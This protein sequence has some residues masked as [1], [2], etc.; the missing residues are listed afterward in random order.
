[1]APLSAPRL[2][3]E[4]GGWWHAYVCGAHGV[5][6]AHDGLLSGAFP[7]EGAR[8]PYG[9]RLD[10]PAVHG[11]WA[12]LAH[13]A[14]ARRIRLLAAVSPAQAL[15][16]LIEYGERYAELT[17]GGRHEQAQP[18]ML[19]GR[20]FH[21]ALS[22]AIWAV[23]LGHAAWTLAEHEIHGLD[24]LLP[25]LDSLERAAREARATLVAQD[26]FTSNYTAWLNAAGAVTARAAALI[27]GGTTDAQ[28]ARDSTAEADWLEGS[29]GLHAHILAA[30]APDGWEWEAS[31]YYHGFVLRAYL[32]QLRGTRPGDLP[33][34]VAARLLGMIAALAGTASPGGVL[35][36]LHDGPYDRP[37]TAA[38]HAELG[39]LAAGFAAPD[40]LA[41]VTARAVADA[42][43][44]HDRL[45]SFLSGWFAGPPRA[46]VPPGT[47]FPD[48]GLAVLR[49]GGVHAVLDYGPHGGSHGHHDKLALYLYG[50]HTPWQ[51]D[52]G[53]VPYAEDRWRAY[54][55]GP[56]AHP[57]PGLPGLE[58]AETTGTLDADDPGRVTASC[59][60]AY[61]GVRLTRTVLT[62]SGYLADLCALAPKADEPVVLRLRPGVP[63]EAAEGDGVV[64][65]VWRGEE[66]LRGLHVADAPAV[67]SAFPAP[68]LADDPQR[69]RTCLDWAA[70]GPVTF[71]SV[72]QA[73]GAEP[74]VLGVAVADGALRVT[75]A[76][77]AVEEHRL[78]R[79]GG[80]AEE[81][82]LVSA[83]GDA[84]ERRLP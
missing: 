37:A 5:E 76:G 61:P 69:A 39:V 45:E 59:D 7:P 63:V 46:A 78:P 29:H 26:R 58:P 43:T 31:T 16:P 11:A 66:E 54:F 41:A 80:A 70:R 23:S 40:H 1:M 19:R 44:G 57:A 74:G 12:A 64:T 18:W 55:A 22:E 79:A 33:D 77:G 27:R 38:E 83:G 81:H 53:Q 72:Y 84:E 67:L 48:A 42:G 82:L 50:E 49:A 28:E 21:Q 25:L 62:G 32:L 24:P 17:S 68:G 2:P 75:L 8:C 71:C 56:D 9:C 15:P 14:C 65:T 36:A 10:T 34:A 4:R 47:R 30:V 73:A 20:M 3:R 35:P 51:P 52:P 6:L 13:Q 60:D